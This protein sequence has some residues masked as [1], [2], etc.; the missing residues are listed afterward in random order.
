M[1]DLSKLS[2]LL[3]SIMI[4]TGG[5]FGFVKAKS[6]ASLIA[7]S[8]STL[9]LLACFCFSLSDKRSG[10]L[11]AFAVITVLD[12]IFC[13]RLA[14]TRKF[15]P[16]GMLFLLCLVEQAILFYPAFYCP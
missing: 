5:I 6:K 14:R 1:I 12:L 4:L 7:S 2:I 10:C 16:S 13:V 15:M 8:I 9:A 3:F 11:A